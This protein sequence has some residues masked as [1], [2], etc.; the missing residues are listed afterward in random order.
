MCTWTSNTVHN[1]TKNKAWVT[2]ADSGKT[3]MSTRLFRVDLPKYE[4]LF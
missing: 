1:Q 4:L 3:F 2:S